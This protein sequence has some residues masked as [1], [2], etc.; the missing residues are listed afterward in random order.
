MNHSTKPSLKDTTN[1]ENLPYHLFQGK[2]H[3]KL[4]ITLNKFDFINHRISVSDP[5]LLINDYDLSLQ[6]DVAIPEDKKQAL[7]LIQAAI[8]QSANVLKQD[9]KQLPGQLLSRLDSLD[10][11]YIKC[12]LEKIKRWGKY[13]WLRPVEVNLLTPLSPLV[14]TIPTEHPEVACAAISGDGKLTLSVGKEDAV[15]QLW[16]LSTGEL[17][18]TLE[19]KETW[20]CTRRGMSAYP[21]YKEELVA[22]ITDEEFRK[23]TPVSALAIS[24]EG[25]WALSGTSC[26]RSKILYTSEAGVTLI[27]KEC[28]VELWNLSEGKSVLTFSMGFLDDEISS[29][30]LSSDGK[31]ALMGTV[32]GE[33][34]TCDFEKIQKEKPEYIEWPAKISYGNWAAKIHCESFPMP[35]GVKAVALSPDGRWALAASN[36]TLKI[37]D[38]LKGCLHQIIP[39]EP[40]R[41]VTALCLNIEGNVIIQSKD[42]GCS[43]IM[44]KIDEHEASEKNIIDK[45]ERK[46]SKLEINPIKAE[47]NS[48][49]DK[50]Q[51]YLFWTNVKS[52]INGL[53]YLRKLK[54]KFLKEIPIQ[55][56][57]RIIPQAISSDNLWAISMTNDGGIQLWDLSGMETTIR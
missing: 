19:M 54:S 20:N 12:F 4:W 52:F 27:P 43:L 39:L 48:L 46:I 42:A 16:K 36:D 17:V 38:L 55:L 30:A 56:P 2:D 15:L 7:R 29:L 13:S 25:N 32:M 44:L 41:E 53:E 8:R 37:W 45:T 9:K 47:K 49:K 18:K 22:S 6:P 40:S 35:N 1:L 50:S 31:Y 3:D 26:K 28:V 14:R 11:N 24:P 57:F 5:Q 10:N 34:V 51:Y 21:R 23:K 33:L